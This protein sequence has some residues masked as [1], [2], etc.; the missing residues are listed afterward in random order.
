MPATSRKHLALF[1]F[2]SVVAVVIHGLTG[3]VHLPKEFH[4]F[5]AFD[6]R[7]LLWQNIRS[8]PVSEKWGW[9]IAPLSM[10]CWP[11]I[12]VFT[13]ETDIRPFGKK[14]AAHVVGSYGIGRF[15]P[16]E[17]TPYSGVYKE[18]APAILRFSTATEPSA[19]G[20]MTP[21]VAVKHFVDGKPSL[22]YAA[23]YTFDNTVEHGLDFFSY[24]LSTHGPRKSD[25]IGLKLLAWGF[26]QISKISATLG[27]TISLA[28]TKRNGRKVANDEV[29]VPFA[30]IL[31]P[32]EELKGL[33][34]DYEGSDVMGEVVRQVG[35]KMGGKPV[36][37]V[38][39]VT[40]PDFPG[41]DSVVPIGEYV[42]EE[43]SCLVTSGWGDR[44]LFFQ[45]QQFEGELEWKPEWR[46]KAGDEQFLLLEGLPYK[47]KDFLP[48][49]T[50]TE[51]QEEKEWV[52]AEA[53]EI[54]KEKSLERENRASQ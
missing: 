43:S 50:V 34:K 45:Q 15:V 24:P 12:K 32:H 20:G 42:L 25:N 10:L 2:V 14:R 4:S 27:G 3:H 6:Q 11:M 9:A 47:W 22:N 1:A 33:L 44:H 28:Q 30:I 46:E 5:S 35:C 7:K 41:E 31:Q 54:E 37:R 29:N 38:L 17:D 53:E 36:Y 8:D 13:D 39:A 40:G 23:M 18:G 19:K 26:D 52:R 21:A 48:K 16:S 49:W 51:S